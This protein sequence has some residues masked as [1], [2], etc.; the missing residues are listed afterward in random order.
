MGCVGKIIGFTFILIYTGGKFI[1]AYFMPDWPEGL[2]SVGVCLVNMH[3]L[4]FI[5]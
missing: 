2:V 1:L 5:F 3:L 4:H